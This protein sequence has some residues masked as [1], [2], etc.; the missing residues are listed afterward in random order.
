MNR[1][2]ISLGGGDFPP[3]FSPAGEDAHYLERVRRVRGGEEVEVLLEDGRIGLY[4]MEYRGAAPFLVLSRELSGRRLKGRL[5][6][7]QP[8]L[9]RAKLELVLQKAA[10][11][12]AN[13]VVLFEARRSV[14]TW[15]PSERV[16]KLARARTLLHEACRQSGL[17]PLPELA[18]AGSLDEALTL[19]EPGTGGFFLW[20]EAEPGSELIPGSSPDCLRV[21]IGPEGGF[22]ESEVAALRQ[23]GLL[24]RR[25]GTLILRS[26]TASIAALVLANLALGRWQ[27]GEE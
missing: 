23:A 22:E 24:P 4:L 7:L 18:F 16:H 13:S 8:L 12:G 20:E 14:A 19:G 2:R 17:N 11:L 6:L 10:E 21:C 26:E 5:V 15:P 25:I 9:Q 1:P 27:A 3:S